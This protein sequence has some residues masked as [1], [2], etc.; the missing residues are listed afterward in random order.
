MSLSS[1]PLSPRSVN[2]GSLVGKKIHLTKSNSKKPKTISQKLSYR[3]RRYTSQMIYYV[4]VEILGFLMEF[5]TLTIVL[6]EVWRLLTL[7]RTNEKF[8]WLSYESFNDLFFL[9]SICMWVEA[10]TCVT[11]ETRIRDTLLILNPK[12]VS[13]T[14]FFPES[15]SS[16]QMYLFLYVNISYISPFPQNR[17]TSSHCDYLV[18]MIITS[19]SYIRVAVSFFRLVVPI[20]R[21]VV[22]MKKPVLQ[23]PW[24]FLPTPAFLGSLQIFGESSGP[25][26]LDSLIT[27]LLLL[28]PFTHTFYFIMT[29]SAHVVQLLFALLLWFSILNAVHRKHIS[30]TEQAKSC[31]DVKKDDDLPNT[32]VQPLLPL[33]SS[34]R[35][36]GI[37]DR[38]VETE[39]IS[40]LERTHMIREIGLDCDPNSVD[41]IRKVVE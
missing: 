8:S 33:E 1:Q 9:H 5:L 29:R 26:V 36:T 30:N 14:Y 23:K 18:V 10:L 13:K 24:K 40:T 27:Q 6:G 31:Y 38:R 25:Q 19:L 20:I 37:Q 39:N 22:W 16:L 21:E 3:L 32:A 41:K 17:S 4:V 35:R 28:E 7:G 2:L 12:H 34:G 15:S 11:W